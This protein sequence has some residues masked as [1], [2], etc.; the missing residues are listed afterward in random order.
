PVRPGRPARP[1]EGRGSLRPLPPRQVVDRIEGHP[2]TIVFTTS[3]RSA[4]RLTAR[5]NEEASAR[6]AQ[7][8]TIARAHHGSMSR[9]ER[10]TIETALKS[11]T[12]PAVV[13]TSSLELGI[14]MGAVDLVVQVG[15]P[16]SVAATLQRIGRAGHQVGATSR[17]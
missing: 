9:S 14:D 7:D 11:G 8:R 10:E 12:L 13:A 5:I 2:S 1:R 15:A 17:G 6:S 3:R 4:E 16:G